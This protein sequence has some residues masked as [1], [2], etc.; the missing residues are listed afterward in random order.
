MML[1]CD[2]FGYIYYHCNVNWD[3]N[4]KKCVLSDFI[5]K[6]GLGKEF[7]DYATERARQE[8]NDY[9]DRNAF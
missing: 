2:T 5:A 7:F 9:E 6:M 3:D 1:P 8:D 4:S